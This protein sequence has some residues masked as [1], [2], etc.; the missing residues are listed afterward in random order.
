MNTEFAPPEDTTAA[1]GPSRRSFLS[2]TAKASS[3]A[4]PA[5]IIAGASRNEASAAKPVRKGTPLPQLYRGWNTKNFQEIQNDE[6]VHVA[7]IVKILGA[8]ARPMPTFQNLE[9]STYHQFA[10]MSQAFENTGVGA[11]LGALPYIFDTTDYL[12]PA[13]SIALVEAYHSGYLNTLL[14]DPIVPSSANFA[15]ALTIDEVVAA[16]TPYIASLNGGPPA[17]FSTTP[18]AANDI[19]ILNFALILEYLEKTFYDT[20]VPKFY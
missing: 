4:F 13:A 9:A 7:T 6:D 18:S 8:N 17:T 20:N 2:W 19:A 1:E 14:N 3:V 5:I 11:Y 12:Q 10:V 15:Q 16:A